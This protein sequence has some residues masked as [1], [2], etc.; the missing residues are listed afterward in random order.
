MQWWQFKVHLVTFD[1][2]AQNLQPNLTKKIRTRKEGE[3][4]E[5]GEGEGRGGGGG[6]GG[7][8]EGRGGEERDFV[9]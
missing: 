7:E 9:I 2:A 5:E 1:L 8:G 6:G 4:E 3:G